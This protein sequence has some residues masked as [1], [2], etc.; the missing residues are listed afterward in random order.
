MPAARS[1]PRLRRITCIWAIAR[2]VNGALDAMQ[3]SYLGPEFEQGR[4]RA[5][6]HGER[7]AL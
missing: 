4:D 5:P 6:A 3:G 2:Y 1:E 7:S